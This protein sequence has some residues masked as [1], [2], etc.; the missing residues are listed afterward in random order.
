[1]T[2]AIFDTDFFIDLHRGNVEAATVWQRVQDGTLTASV[3][4]ITAYE[5]WVGAGLNR[6]EE[7]FYRAT[8]SFLEEAV[9]TSSA[10]MEAGV[11][12][13]GR[14]RQETLVR[15]SFSA[16]TAFER[17]ERVITANLRDF[18]QFPI[19]VEAYR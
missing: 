19:E 8:F 7:T 12:L 2:D 11:W 14:E 3:S 9:L 4:P 5:L 15:D 10:A 18:R 6:E 13:R 1:V 17:G 16:A